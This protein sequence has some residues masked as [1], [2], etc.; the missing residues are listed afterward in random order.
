MEIETVIYESKKPTAAGREFLAFIVV[1][2]DEMDGKKKTGRKVKDQLP[3]AFYGR[4]AIEVVEKA[5]KFWADETAKARA[6]AEHGKAL[7]ESRRKKAA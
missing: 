2:A 7:G 4:S 5:R 3:V 1:D 6:K